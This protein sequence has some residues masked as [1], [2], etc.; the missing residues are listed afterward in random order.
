MAEAGAQGLIY[1]IQRFSVHDGPGIRT[2][3]FFKGCPLRCRWCQNPESLR[4]RPEIAFLAD[5]CHESG[6]CL[7]SCPLGAIAPGQERILRD[8]CDGCGQCLDACDWGALQSVGRFWTARVLAAEIARDEPFFRSSGGGATLSGGEPTFQLPF[9]LE[10]T[11]ELRDRGIGVG[12]QTCGAFSW[13]SFAPLLPLLDFVFFDLKHLD[14]EEHRRLTGSDNAALRDNARR[15]AASGA[16]V[17]FR[18][19]VVPGLNDGAESLA[20]VA[21]FLRELERP[22]LH[23]L[24]YHAMGEA[25]LARMGFPIPPLGLDFDHDQAV[26]CLEAAREILQHHGIEVTS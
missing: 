23:L 18:M 8:R 2:T 16:R 7:A 12:L 4:P 26:R 9:A 15:L 11:R 17:T 3:V 13:E 5:R 25:K 19:P 1:D 21:G 10:L 14:S 20:A 6:D 24:A 22:R